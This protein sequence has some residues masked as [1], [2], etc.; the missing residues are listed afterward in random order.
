MPINL[1]A[2]REFIFANARLL[3]RHRA[4]VLLDGAPADAVV[5]AL[6]AYRNPDGGYGHALEP[7]VRTPHSETTAALHG[8]EVLRELDALEDPMVEDIAAWVAGVAD[9]DGGVPFILPTAAHYPRGPWMVPS[10]GGSHLTFGLAAVLNLASVRNDWLVKATQWCWQRLEQPEELGGYWLK[11][12]LD[13]LDAIPEDAQA[14]AARPARRRPGKPR[15][16]PAGRRWV[17]FRFPE[18][19]TRTD[20]RMARIPHAPCTRDAPHTQPAHPAIA[21]PATGM[22]R[23]SWP[24]A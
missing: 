1:P 20:S 23:A 15:T 2:A 22:T 5:Q 8:L 24:G 4:A 12:A 14:R 17:D 9:P 11:Y 18:L 10:D 3:D 19:V 6:R 7:D 16:Q 13:F 21:P